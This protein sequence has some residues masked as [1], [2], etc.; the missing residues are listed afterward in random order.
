VAVTANG[1]LADTATAA[2][3]SVNDE[4]GDVDLDAADVGAEA[5]G[6]AATAV[7]AHAGASDPHG[8]RAFTVTTVAAHSMAAD[9]HGDRAYTD[10]AVATHAADTTAVHGITDTSAL[11]TSAGATTKVA[12]HA[13]AADPHGDR[14]FTTAAVATHAAATDPHGD[15]AYADTGLAGKAALPTTPVNVTFPVNNFGHGTPNAQALILT[16]GYAMLIGRVAATGANSGNAVVFQLPAGHLPAHEIAPTIRYVGTSA[17]TGALTIGTDGL[18]RYNTA[19]TLAN[20]AVLP[21]DGI[22]YKVAA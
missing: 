6:T 13:G 21:L 22:I 12:T 7:T 8:D 3:T 19:L 20:A 1:Y 9:P 15:R 18:A 14:A 10:T 11:E 17:S 5:A 16:P 2:V 4:T